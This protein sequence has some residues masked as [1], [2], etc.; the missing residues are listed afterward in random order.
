M[1]TIRNLIVLLAILIVAASCH[2]FGN[3]MVIEN[4][5]DRLEI[6]SS[7]EIRFTDDESA[8]QSISKYGYIRY[9]KNDQKLFAGYTNKGDLKY[10]L[11]DNGKKINPESPEGKKFIADAI[12]EMIATGMDAEG[13]FI[14]VIAKGGVRAVL[15]EVD[16][17]DNDFIKSMYLEFLIASDSLKPAQ[18]VEITNKID[19]KLGSDFEKGKLLKKYTANHLKDS[20]TSTAYFEAVK[21]VGSDFEKA[22]ALKYIIKQQ[23]GKAQYGSVINA[24]NSVGSDFEKAN[25]LKE[26]IRAGKVDSSLANPF[27]EATNRIGSDF[28]KANII[29][30][31]IDYGLYAN[32]SFGNLLGSIGRVG[33]DFERANI[34]KKLAAR[35]IKADAHWIGLIEK[36]AELSSEFEK[37]NVLLQIASHMPKSEEVKASYMKAA[38][39][40]NAEHEYGRAVKALN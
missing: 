40:I 4:G 27:L 15:T 38:K 10:E 16:R 28:E 29:K 3:R 20:L 39:T 18:L 1:K 33:S 21:N 30:E 6:E 12:K 7:G 14:R 2:R 37:C 13:R 25:I 19:K 26:L 17:L 34:L 35:D 32:E 9:R 22:N 31:M 11:F 5:K 36:T 24:S 23:L 8:I